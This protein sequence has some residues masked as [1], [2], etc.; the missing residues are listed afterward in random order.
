MAD[1]SGTRYVELDL[2]DSIWEHFFSVFPLVVVGT[3]DADG[4]DDLAPKHLAIPLSWGNH[5]GFVC[6]PRHNTYQN[7]LREKQFTVTYM[8]PSQTV[9]A[10]L[11]ATPRCDDGSKPITKAL[12][13]FEADKVAA[14]FLE[15]GYLFLEC[16]LDQTVDNLNDNS[17]IIGRIISAKIANDALRSTEQDDQ[18][19]LNE[20]PL[21]AYLYPGRFAE[22]S[23]TRTLPF[24]AGFKR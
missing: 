7:I 9:L 5:F 2:S 6:T 19:L 23:D 21:L 17:L 13:T 8:R 18:D 22:I 12:Q 16:E 15:D 24:P 4:S 1:K 3:R 14:S 10:S 20:S 11:A